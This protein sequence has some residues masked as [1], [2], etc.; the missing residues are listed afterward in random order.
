MADIIK[1]TLAVSV[2]DTEE[3]RKQE[4][5]DDGERQLLA[6]ASYSQR[7]AISE[8]RR[9]A[10]AVPAGGRASLDIVLIADSAPSFTAAHFP[11]FSHSL[12]PPYR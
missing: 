2:E 6:A 7:G 3:R 11:S 10:D 8:S 4:V 5:Q 1:L 12:A 9:F